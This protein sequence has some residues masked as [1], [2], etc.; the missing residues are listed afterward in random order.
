MTGGIF[1]NETLVDALVDTAYTIGPASKADVKALRAEVD[2]LKVS[3]WTNAAFS[4]S[5]HTYRL[6]YGH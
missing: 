2:A 1:K 6:C 5:C 3:T 4:L